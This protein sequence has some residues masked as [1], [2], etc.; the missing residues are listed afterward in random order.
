MK[1]LTVTNLNEKAT[2][3]LLALTISTMLLLFII[4][5]MFEGLEKQ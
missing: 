3:N 5:W 1:W 4:G 2:P